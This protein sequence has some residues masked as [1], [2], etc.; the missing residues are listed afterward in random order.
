MKGLYMI[1][2]CVVLVMM[3]SSSIF[4]Q[5]ETSKKIVMHRYLV[6]RTFPNGLEIPLNMEG[7]QMCLNVVSVN[8]EDNVSWVHSYVT[9]DHKKTFCIYD[10]PSPEA[11]RKSAEANGLPVDSIVEVSVLDPYFYR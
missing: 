9:T 10:A 7:S 1:L 4:A 2:V 5:E 3:Y 8:A 6:E 11:I